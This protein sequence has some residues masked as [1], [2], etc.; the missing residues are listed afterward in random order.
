M[1]SLITSRKGQGSLGAII[2]G[3]KR[4]QNVIIALFSDTFDDRNLKLG[5]VVV[6][7]VGF[8]KM[9]ILMTFHGGQRS[10]GAIICAKIGIFAEKRNFF[11]ATMVNV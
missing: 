8:P 11:S 6:C 7:D 9:Y 2:V 10:S 1:P 4:P 3:G 5:T